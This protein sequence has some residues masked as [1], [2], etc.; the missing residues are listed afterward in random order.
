MKYKLTFSGIGLGQFGN[1]GLGSGF[2]GIRNGGYGGAPLVRIF[3]GGLGG[4]RGLNNR[5]GQGYGL[6][7]GRRMIGGLGGKGYNRFLKRE[8]K[9]LEDEEA[10]KTMELDKFKY[11]IKNWGHK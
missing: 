11:A 6:S 1:Y 9:S 4:L 8:G 5:L 10:Q 3:S 7:G 2:G